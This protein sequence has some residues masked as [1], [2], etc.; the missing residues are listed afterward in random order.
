MSAAPLALL[1]H[2][3]P[4]PP[5]STQH[6]G[7]NTAMRWFLNPVFWVPELGQREG[8]EGAGMEHDPLR[9]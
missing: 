2:P 9:G 4:E 1:G 3:L 6:A 7:A 8:W 5:L